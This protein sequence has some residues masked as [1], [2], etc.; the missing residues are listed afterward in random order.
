MREIIKS[1]KCRG[2]SRRINWEANQRIQCIN[3][4][5]TLEIPEVKVLLMILVNIRELLLRPQIQKADFL[6]LIA[7]LNRRLNHLDIYKTCRKWVK[8]SF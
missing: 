3:Q 6:Q 2:A 5:I 7:L 4:I 1:L 8:S